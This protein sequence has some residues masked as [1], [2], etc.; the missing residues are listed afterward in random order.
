M[1]AVRTYSTDLTHVLFGNV[2]GVGPR[3]LWVIGVL[4]ALVLATILLLYKE[5]LITTFD[6]TL[7]ATLHLPTNLL[8]NVMLVLLALTVVV[9]LQTVGVGLVAAML[10]TPPA[11]A[12]LLTR[13]LAAMMVVAA[14]IGA[15]SAVGGLYISFYVNVAS[16]AAVVL[17]CTVCFV[18]VYLFAPERGIAWGLARRG[19]VSVAKG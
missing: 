2:L 8:R 5:F 11:T 6:P 17:F 10:V 3:D 16:G 9:S 4:G 18:L 7:A 15:V 12:Y 1:S 13:R 14:I 19:R